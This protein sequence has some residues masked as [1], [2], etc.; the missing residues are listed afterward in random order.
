MRLEAISP[1][2]CLGYDRNASYF[3][4]PQWDIGYTTTLPLYGGIAIS[5]DN[6]SQSRKAKPR[7]EKEKGSQ[8]EKRQRKG[9][10]CDNGG[11]VKESTLSRSLDRSR[12]SVTE[13]SNFPINGRVSITKTSDDC[14]STENGAYE[15][16]GRA[17]AAPFTDQRDC[18][19][20]YCQ[21]NRRVAWGSL[22]R[23]ANGQATTEACRVL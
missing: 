10:R 9:N 4:N 8:K 20:H 21:W 18:S 1:G 12:C 2:V 16:S 23:A 19:C 15:T 14:L 7:N 22:R 17:G 6:H 13:V 5:R 11:A 3:A